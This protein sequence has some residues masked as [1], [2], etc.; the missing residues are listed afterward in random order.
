VHIGGALT[1][2]IFMLLDKDIQFAL[3][4]KLKGRSNFHS[5]VHHYSGYDDYKRNKEQYYGTKPPQ[6]GS[7]YGNSSGEHSRDAGPGMDGNSGGGYRRG[8][9]EAQFRDLRPLDKPTQEEIDR[10][11]DKISQSG[12][13]NLTEREKQILF[14]ASKRL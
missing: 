11:L 4:D 12:Y 3:K 13:K 5:D 2:F 10:I 9:E 14:E 7:R 6:S 1:A 8:S